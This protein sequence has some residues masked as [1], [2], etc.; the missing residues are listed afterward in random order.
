MGVLDN[1]M[2]LGIVDGED[3]V[4]STSNLEAKLFALDERLRELPTD[5]PVLDRAFLELEKSRNLT[6]LD[7]GE[8]AWPLARAVFDVYC[9]GKDWNKA[10]QACE[11][12]FLSEQ[13]GALSALGHGVW[14][15]V[16]FP[17]ETELSLAMLQHIVNETP[18]DADGAAVAAATGVYIVELRAKEDEKENLSFFANQLLGAVSR[19]HSNV[20]SQE[21]FA[22]WTARL[23]LDDPQKFLIR[24]R[25]V[26]DVLVQDDWWVDRDVLREDMPEN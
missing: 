20:E 2:T 3:A 18:D 11:I 26:V 4:Q 6:A 25:N 9:Q 22:A 8:Q 21:D 14:L 5:A 15:S 10:V 1:N 24:L 12:M 16:S 17:V 13:D 19:R 23:E 7:R